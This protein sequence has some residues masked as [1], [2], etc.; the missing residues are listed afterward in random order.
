[1]YL[2][3]NKILCSPPVG[4]TWTLPLSLCFPLSFHR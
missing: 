2:I 4:N 1:M 3:S